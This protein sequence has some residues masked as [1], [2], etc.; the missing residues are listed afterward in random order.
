MSEKPHQK[1]HET[2]HGKKHEDK[3]EHGGPGPRTTPAH[4]EGESGDAE[5]RREADEAVA[6]RMGTTDREGADGHTAKRQSP[7]VGR[8][9][10]TEKHS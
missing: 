4:A 6:G 9:E 10:Q 3:A 1:P 7:G 5:A 2:E 8:E